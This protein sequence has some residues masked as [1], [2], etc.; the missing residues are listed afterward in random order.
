MAN[1]FVMHARI[2]LN[3]MH[4]LENKLLAETPHSIFFSLHIY[5][6]AAAFRW[7]IRCGATVRDWFHPLC[8]INVLRTFHESVTELQYIWSVSSNRGK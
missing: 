4:M 6:A 3:A 1:T 8:S 7:F 2:H 5:I